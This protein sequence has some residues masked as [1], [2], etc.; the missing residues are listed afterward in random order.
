MRPLLL[1]FSIKKT[2]SNY[3]HFCLSQIIQKDKA[4][5]NPDLF[6]SEAKD[7]NLRYNKY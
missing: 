3:H 2:F 1:L 5:R 6:F 4:L 7:K